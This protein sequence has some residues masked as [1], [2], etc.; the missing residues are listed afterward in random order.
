VCWKVS[1]IKSKM[2]EGQAK[3]GKGSI[4]TRN[5]RVATNVN[6]LLFTFR[7]TG[8][9]FMSFFLNCLVDLREKKNER[10]REV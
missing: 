4:D 9:W 6:L 7:K 1:K 8:K 3:D 10:E 2:G 5:D